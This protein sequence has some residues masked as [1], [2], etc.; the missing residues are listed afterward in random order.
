M[1]YIFAA[2]AFGATVVFVLT[3]SGWMLS[4]AMIIGHALA[5]PRSHMA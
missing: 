1:N 2:L 5:S 3:G 4:G